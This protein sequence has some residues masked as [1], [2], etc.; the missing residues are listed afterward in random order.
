MLKK[1]K[2]Q[3]N[4]VSCANLALSKTNGARKAVKCAVS[5]LIRQK[6]PLFATVLERI[7]LILLETPRA[8]ARV[9]STISM[10]QISRRVLL[11]IS[12]IVSH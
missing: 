2:S 7:E 9:A 6:E 12:Q 10:N 4:N 5:T 1:E 8:A 11:V 3:K